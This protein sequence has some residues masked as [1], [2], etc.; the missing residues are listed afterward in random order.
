MK[1]NEG[2]TARETERYNELLRD[3]YPQPKDGMREAVM[4][5][6]A[7]EKS[8]RRRKS[9]LFVR[10]G[11]IAACLV[12][13]GG[14]IVL[15]APRF[16]AAKKNHVA[17]NYSLASFDKA[18]E[19]C[20]SGNQCSEVLITA[21]D[22]SKETN[23]WNDQ[24][25]AMYNTGKALIEADSDEDD[26]ENFSDNSL[27]DA[28]EPPMLGMAGGS[29]MRLPVIACDNFDVDGDGETE[30]CEITHDLTSELYS[31]WFTVYS[32]DGDKEYKDMFVTGGEDIIFESVDGK[33]MLKHCE[34]YHGI[35]ILDGH[36]SLPTDCEGC[37]LG[38]AL[39]QEQ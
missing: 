28:A 6:I 27:P 15:S 8:A 34:H 14:A 20:D 24:N 16:F 22:D 19:V 39:E 31:V 13:I 18:E 12:I 21:M 32:Q 36:V 37:T 7:A 25:G 9:K 2:M 26:Y 30:Y 11:S 1:E 29:V 17:D 35:E 38:A 10:W 4:Q 33:T 23:E 3:A 5:R